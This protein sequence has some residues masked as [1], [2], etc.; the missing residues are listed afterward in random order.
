MIYDIISYSSAVIGTFGQV[1]SILKGAQDMKKNNEIKQISTN[2]TNS[3]TS[4]S[5]L[6]LLRGKIKFSFCSILFLYQ[7]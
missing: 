7:N 3:K 1:S 5:M 4:G 6:E 2:T